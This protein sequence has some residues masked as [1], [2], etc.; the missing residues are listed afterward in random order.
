MICTVYV[1][2]H[3]YRYFRF[4]SMMRWRGVVLIFFGLMCC[5]LVDAATEGY[6]EARA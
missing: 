2:S 6:T 3:V 1:R 5:S 4:L